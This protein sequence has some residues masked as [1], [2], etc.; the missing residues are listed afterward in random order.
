MQVICHPTQ[1]PD[2]PPPRTLHGADSSQSTKLSSVRNQTSA[3]SPNSSSHHHAAHASTRHRDPSTSPGGGS[4]LPATHYPA[5]SSRSSSPAAICV[6][7]LAE[8][9]RQLPSNKTTSAVAAYSSTSQPPSQSRQT[10][11]MG[12]QGEQL[13]SSRSIGPRYPT[14]SQGI[15]RSQRSHTYSSSIFQPPSKT[16]QNKKHIQSR[17]YTLGVSD[18]PRTPL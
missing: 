3:Q 5:S 8:P 17:G 14:A 1:T 4:P 9:M 15:S 7:T 6:T 10:T 12:N 16:S 11:S 18:A 13:T 2:S